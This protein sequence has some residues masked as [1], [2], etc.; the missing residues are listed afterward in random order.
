PP[1][2]APPRPLAPSRPSE[3]EPPLRSPLGDDAGRRFRRGLLIHRLLQSLPEM[4]PAERARAGRAFLASPLHDLSAGEQ[5]EILGEVLRVLEAPQ[6]APLFGPGSRAEVP[7]AGVVE[8]AAGPQ[9]IAGQVDRLLVE[10]DVIWL[11][12]YKSQRPA[13]E[14]ESEVPALYLRQMAAYRAL[15]ARIY[16]GRAIRG[17]LLW[18]DQPRL[19]QLSDALLR[20]HAP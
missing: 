3:S 4:A 20:G 9:A 13:P 16:P 19:M 8:T 1:E 7:L 2:P 15:L 11:I 14:R 18:T 10:D 5:D 17:Y 12:D 6:L